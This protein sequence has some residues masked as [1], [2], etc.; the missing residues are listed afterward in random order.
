MLTKEKLKNHIKHLEEKH[1]K[2]DKEIQLK[3][4]LHEN[5]LHLEHLKKR[6]LHIKDEIELTKTQLNGKS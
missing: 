2:L 1:S 4:S 5:D 6:K 3:Y